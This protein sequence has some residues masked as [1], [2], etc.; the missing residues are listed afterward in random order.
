MYKFLS[1]PFPQEKWII[2]ASKALQRSFPYT[3]PYIFKF[4][5]EEVQ[6]LIV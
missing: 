6:Y 4:T 1:L 5:I 3:L 2:F